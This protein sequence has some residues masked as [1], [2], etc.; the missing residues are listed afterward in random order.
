VSSLLSVWAAD[1]DFQLWAPFQI[2]HPLT[3]KWD[4][5]MQTEIRM[6][7]DVSDFSQLVLKPAANFK[8][9]DT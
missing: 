5:S 4:V 9:N 2:I 7:E 8:I 6:R 3:D 1:Q